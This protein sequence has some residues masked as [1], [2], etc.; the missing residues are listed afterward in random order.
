MVHTSIEKEDGHF[1]HIEITEN[2]ATILYGRFASLAADRI[3]LRVMQMQLRVAGASQPLFSN[4][5]RFLARLASLLASDPRFNVHK[6]RRMCCDSPQDFVLGRKNAR[7]YEVQSHL[8][9]DT[10]REAAQDPLIQLS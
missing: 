5:A 3:V 4:S 10:H 6:H 7:R 2:R 1:A 8:L 9:P